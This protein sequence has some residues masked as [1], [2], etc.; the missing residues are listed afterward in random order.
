MMKVFGRFAHL[1]A[2]LKGQVMDR[3]MLLALQNFSA[4]KLVIRALRNVSPSQI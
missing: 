1:A 3:G 4:R 2:F